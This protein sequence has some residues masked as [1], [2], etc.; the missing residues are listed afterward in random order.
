MIKKISFCEI[1]CHLF[2]PDKHI[3]G[4]S[5]KI[6]ENLQGLLRKF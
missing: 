3:T 6:S 4:I 1:K 5:K 2:V